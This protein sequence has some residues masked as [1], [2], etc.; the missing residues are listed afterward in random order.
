MNILFHCGA[1]QKL[2][3]TSLVKRCKR[4]LLHVEFLGAN[5]TNFHKICTPNGFIHKF[6]RPND[7]FKTISK[8]VYI[9][10]GNLNGIL[11]EVD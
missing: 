8:A 10:C 7:F 4:G 1:L 2:N 6:C 5:C 11:Q 9:P 3:L